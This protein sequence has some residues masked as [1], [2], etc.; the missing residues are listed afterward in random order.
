MTAEYYLSRIDI[1]SRK[2]GARKLLT[3]PRAMHA[4]VE[5]SLPPSAR[6]PGERFLWRVD[7]ADPKIELYVVSP[8]LPDFTHI[9]EQ[10]GWEREGEK[11]WVSRPY[12]RLL[13]RLETGQAWIFRLTANPTR[14]GKTADGV[15]KRFGHVT[16]AQQLQWLLDRAQPNGFS[17]PVE[18]DGD[19]AVEVIARS[20]DRFS[21][22]R[23]AK[24]AITRA[25]YEGVLEISEPDLLRHALTHGIGRA[26]AYGCG[27]LT[28]APLSVP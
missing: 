16:A 6:R 15:P 25:T 4:A 8:G 7:R 10:A 13:D 5:S 22:G 18:K 3:S 27:L 21:H 11:G 28:L 23:G 24:V 2:R 26:K 14:M 17:I 20:E 19:P 12:A 1:N 9:V